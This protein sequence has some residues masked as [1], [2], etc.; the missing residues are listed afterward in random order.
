MVFWAW[1]NGFADP[2]WG[3]DNVALVLEGTGFL[4]TALSAVV[5]D[6]VG[7]VSSAFHCLNRSEE[8]LNWLFIF[9]SYGENLNAI[10]CVGNS[11]SFIKG[12]VLI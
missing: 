6:A 3:F 12:D 2:S 4:V 9:K 8:P 1:A 5:V 10:Y 11:S 7:L